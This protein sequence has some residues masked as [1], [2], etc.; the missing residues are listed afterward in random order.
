[1]RSWL[2][3]SDGKKKKKEKAKGTRTLGDQDE[4]EIHFHPDK[5]FVDKLP[6]QG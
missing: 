2:A 1:M 4:S 3:V 5:R 6:S